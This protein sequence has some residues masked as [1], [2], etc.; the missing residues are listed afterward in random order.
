MDLS[1][2]R[3]FLV[4]AVVKYKHNN[5]I[6]EQKSIIMTLQNIS[7]STLTNHVSVPDPVYFWQVLE[8]FIILVRLRRF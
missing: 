4:K 5:G 8:I 7:T 6:P 2:D 3:R 1:Y